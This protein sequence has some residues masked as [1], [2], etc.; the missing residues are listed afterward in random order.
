MMF[1]LWTENFYPK[2]N[3][4]IKEISVMLSKK[5]NLPE[6]FDDFKHDV[7]GNWFKGPF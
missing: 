4:I 2:S 7:P 1:I 6:K 3:E 5:I